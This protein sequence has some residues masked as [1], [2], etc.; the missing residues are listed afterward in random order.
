MLLTGHL[1]L[2]FRL[3]RAR[4]RGRVLDHRNHRPHLYGNCSCSASLSRHDARLGS[5]SLGR[6][7]PS[8]VVSRH[9]PTLNKRWVRLDTDLQVVVHDEMGRIP[10]PLRPASNSSYPFVPTLP[11]FTRSPPLLRKP[12]FLPEADLLRDSRLGVPLRFSATTG[13]TCLL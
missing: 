1:L 3:W 12:C 6:F 2:R 10:S 5:S 7:S 11:G 8:E 13:R 9:F 4:R